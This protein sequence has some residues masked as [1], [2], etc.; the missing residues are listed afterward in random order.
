MDAD[1]EL[2]QSFEAAARE[3][4]G[5]PH[6]PSNSDLLELYALYKQAMQGDATGKRPGITSFA[7]RAKYDAWSGMSGMS[8]AQAMKNYVEKVHQLIGRTAP[9]VS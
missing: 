7:A 1:A 8:S 2:T 4:Q 5:L 9:R 6:R 3:V